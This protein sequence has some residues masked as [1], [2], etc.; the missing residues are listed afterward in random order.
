MGHVVEKEYVYVYVCVWGGSWKPI[1]M[2]PLYIL[3]NIQ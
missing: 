2:L 3:F 1:L